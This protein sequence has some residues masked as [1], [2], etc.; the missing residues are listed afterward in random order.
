[1]KKLIT[2]L[3]VAVLAVIMV[4][5]QVW[6][7]TIDYSDKTLNDWEKGHFEDVWDLKACDL[8]YSYTINMGGITNAGW[9][10]TET[11]L[12]QAGYGDIDPNLVGGWMQSN[13]S[14]IK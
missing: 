1:M 5:N 9:A 6:A 10:V 14:S 7:S 8:S 13:L 2:L 3:L 12:R 11:G 4:P